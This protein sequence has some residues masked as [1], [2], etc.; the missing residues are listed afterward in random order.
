MKKSAARSLPQGNWYISGEHR[1]DC[2]LGLML[3]TDLAIISIIGNVSVYS[4]PVDSGLGHVSHL[5]YCP[6]VVV[7][8]TEHPLIQ[9][10]VYTHSV[11]L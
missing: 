5:L 3:G 2:L 11:S 1:L 4:G 9:L 8:I 7:E 6:M 10:R